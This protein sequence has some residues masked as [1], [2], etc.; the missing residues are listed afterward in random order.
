MK[1]SIVVPIFNAGETLGRCLGSLLAQT[2]R[3][4]E[5]VCVD[6]GSTDGSTDLLRSF[7]ARDRRIV[8]LFQDNHGVE[9]ARA[10]ALDH[11]T[12]D[13]V[14]FCD[15]DDEFE[16]EMC[17]R[18]ACTM[19]RD[20]VDLVACSTK[21]AGS[22][23]ETYRR[24]HT[25]T[26]RSGVPASSVCS[27]GVL[28]NK[29]FRKELLDRTGLRF[30]KDPFVRRGFDTCFCRCYSLVSKSASTISAPLVV[31]Y[32]REGSIQSLRRSFRLRRTTDVLHALPEMLAFLDRNGIRGKRAEPFF[33]WYDGQV[34]DCFRFASTEDRPEGVRLVAEALAPWRPL[35]PESCT[36]LVPI[37]SGDEESLLRSFREIDDWQRRFRLEN[38]LSGSWIG[39]RLLTIAGLARKLVRRSNEGR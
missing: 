39:R 26:D 28:W 23:P 4:I 20:A 29:A 6:D 10:E 27:D 36:W 31:H 15:S 37:V 8:A 2:M 19:E 7:A 22:F 9:W 38:A 11:A 14:L 5:I 25:K 34:R 3:E 18:M 32:R 12:G 35:L 24:K 16:S 33:R 17:E 13:V 21:L 30:P 1:A